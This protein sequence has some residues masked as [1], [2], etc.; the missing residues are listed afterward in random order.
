MPTGG[1]SFYNILEYLALPNVAACGGSWIVKSEDAAT[2][3]GE[4]RKVL[5]KIRGIADV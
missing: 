4:T 5:N 1:I 2:I 3:A